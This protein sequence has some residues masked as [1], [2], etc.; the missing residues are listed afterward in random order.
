MKRPQLL[1]LYGLLRLIDRPAGIAVDDAAHELAC[2]ARTIRRDLKVLQDAGFYIDR[3]GARPFRW[4]F[5][6]EGFKL[7]EVTHHGLS[8]NAWF[9]LDLMREAAAHPV[10]KIVKKASREN[11]CCQPF[12][13][14]CGCMQFRE[15]I[16]DLPQELVDEFLRLPRDPALER[17]PNFGPFWHLIAFHSLPRTEEERLQARRDRQLANEEWE[18]RATQARAAARDRK[19]ARLA[20]K[21]RLA[22]ERHAQRRAESASRKQLFADLA[23][24]PIEER[25]RALIGQPQRPPGFFSIEPEEINS[26]VLTGIDPGTRTAMAERISKMRKKSWRDLRGRLLGSAPPGK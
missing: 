24:L 21:R 11:W 13:T 25:I 17:L 9:L 18:R 6:E 19:I 3:G 7:A 16:R 5:A 1:R 14:T 4:R 12:C 22:A 20:E 8:R 26:E 23:A 2:A 15:A 10:A